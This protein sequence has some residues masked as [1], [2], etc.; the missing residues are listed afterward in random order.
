MGSMS[1]DETGH[2]NCLKNGYKIALPD[3]KAC[4]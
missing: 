1:H 2:A 4:A 3:N